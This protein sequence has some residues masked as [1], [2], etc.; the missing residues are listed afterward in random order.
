[1]FR[2]GT[3]DRAGAVF[4]ALADRTRRRVVDELSSDGPLTATQLAD[5]L[6]V[7]R[8]AVGKHLSAL[9]SAGLATGRRSGRETRFALRTEPF[10]QAEAWM[11]A[12]GATW[13]RRL[14]HFKQFVENEEQ[15]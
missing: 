11:A 12:I 14:D 8:Q 6:P 4:A 13:E 2:S 1:M 10:G 9:A 5:R 15:T 7:S 3:E